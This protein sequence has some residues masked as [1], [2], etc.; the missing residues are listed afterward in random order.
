MTPT[1]LIQRAAADGVRLVLS[2]AETIKATGCTAA[3][4][5]WLPAIREHKVE[6]IAALQLVPVPGEIQNLIA[7]VMALRQ[8][9]ESDREAFSDDWRQDP[10]GIG[11]GLRHLADYYGRGR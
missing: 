10:E 2:P 6:L 4:S 1:V 8:C 11:R 7:K 3:L 5:H 9:P